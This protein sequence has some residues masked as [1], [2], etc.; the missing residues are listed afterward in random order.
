[1]KQAKDKPGFKTV[2]N[3]EHRVFMVHGFGWNTQRF[4][5]N[6]EDLQM[7]CQRFEKKQPYHIFEFWNNKPKK[8]SIKKV[9]SLLEANELD[10]TF[11]KSSVKL[12]EI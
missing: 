3:N 4:F 12:A 9:I 2:I 11:F 7:C 6:M 10:A 8:L 5:C 1:M